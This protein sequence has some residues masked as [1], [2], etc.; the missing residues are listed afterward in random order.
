MV[1]TPPNWLTGGFF[2]FREYGGYTD[3]YNNIY[4]PHD[5]GTKF[6][7]LDGSAIYKHF[8]EDTWTVR[9]LGLW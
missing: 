7:M 2:T 9:A 6:F 3:S 1:I 8:T 5:R 4:F